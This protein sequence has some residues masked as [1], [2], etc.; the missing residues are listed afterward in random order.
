MHA[1]L[2]RST[3]RILG[4]VLFVALSTLACN[5][6]REDG[7]EAPAVRGA[8]ARLQELQPTDVAVAPIRDQTDAQRVPLDLFRS[9]F[10]ETLLERRY[11]PL[12]PDY[13]DANWVEASFRGTP[14]PDALLTVSVSAWDPSHLFSTGRVAATAEIVLYE[15]S[16]TTGR[17]LWQRT[18]RH[19]VD[20][21]DGRGN[22]P[23]AGQDW[24]PKA[25]RL[26]ARE[27]LSELPMRDPVAAHKREP[28]VD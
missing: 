16:D 18:L 1:M 26:F 19:E 15:G 2:A 6:T 5:A 14:P 7:A 9:A 4:R 24:I 8:L 21:G 25:V 12:A 11:S 27:A 23:T 17:V 13:V 3:V 20:L 22:P 28:A 10:A